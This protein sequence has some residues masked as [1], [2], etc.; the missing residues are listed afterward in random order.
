MAKTN[1]IYSKD[2]TNLLTEI[3]D[4]ISQNQQQIFSVVT[5]QKVV[6]SWQIGELVSKHLAK[7]SSENYKK[8]LFKKLETDLGLT[9]TVLYKMH[10]FHKSYP[11][12]PKDDEKLNWSH[13][14]VL[15]GVKEGEE[16]KRLE[17]LVKEKDWS[18]DKLQQETKKLKTS[19]L[20]ATKQKKLAAV[21]LVARRGELFNYSLAKPS[22]VDGTCLDCGFGI[23]KRFDEKLTSPTKIIETVKKEKNYKLK[24]SQTNPR[25][26]NAYKS[27]LSRVVDGDTIHVIL[28]LGFEIFHEEIL[29]LRAINAAEAKTKE[30]EKATRALKK[31]LKNVPFLIVKTSGTDQHG[32]YVADVFLADE[33]GKMSEQEVANEGIFL[34]KL[35]VEKRVAAVV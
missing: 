5:R 6:M 3:R 27:Y 21:K 33:E 8:T 31:I 1:L 18:S 14:R 10:S 12:L 23:F 22:G 11:S 24:K 15:S 9:E 7:N 34:N 19:D 25:K 26:L 17:N 28:D 4:C 35:L 2:Y 32:R 29:R 13:Y 30:G 16:R 20:P